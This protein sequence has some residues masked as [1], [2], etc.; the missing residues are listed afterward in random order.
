MSEL[1]DP[2]SGRL[3]S[4]PPLRR[5]WEKVSE[6][7]NGCW[8]WLPP[9][10]EHGYGIFWTGQRKQVAHRF[11]YE[12]IIGKVPDGFELD[13]LCRN[14]KC[15]NP[16][17]LEAVTHQENCQ[18]GCGGIKTGLMNR[19]KT[20]CPQGHAYDE[21]NTYTF[22]NGSR[23]CRICSRK[24]RRDWGKNRKTGVKK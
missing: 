20:H 17:H 15:V 3:L 6:S 16:K 19:A 4:Q 18:R 14:P 10:N 12:T 1:R 21:Q 22:P 8:E 5:F 2:V 11:L 7:E 24:N 13:H 9:T 23:G